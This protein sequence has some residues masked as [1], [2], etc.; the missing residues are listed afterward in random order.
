MSVVVVFIY[1]SL[2]LVVIQVQERR[3]CVGYLLT[4]HAHTHTHTRAA[5][6][7]GPARTRAWVSGMSRA[8]ALWAYP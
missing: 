6:E 2:Y 8:W 4:P 1:P 5:A 7:P 3:V